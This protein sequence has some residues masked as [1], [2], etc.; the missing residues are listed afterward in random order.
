MKA[1]INIF[2]FFF[3]LF[4]HLTAQ[5]DFYRSTNVISTT[6]LS[7]RAEPSLTSK[8]LDVAPYGAKVE[9]LGYKSFGFDTI[10]VKQF[11]QKNNITRT[12]QISG[13][14]RK[15]KYKGQ[16][17]YMFSAYLSELYPEGDNFPVNRDFALLYPSIWCDNNFVF[18]PHWKWFGLYE[19]EGSEGYEW[20]KVNVSFYN[21][22]EGGDAMTSGFI[23]TGEADQGMLFMMGSMKDLRQIEVKGNWFQDWQGSFFDYRNDTIINRSEYFKKWGLQTDSLRRD[24]VT[25]LYL[26]KNG[27]SQLLNPSNWELSSPTYLK[28][29]GDLDGDG[30][31]DFLIDC[32]GDKSSHDILYLSTQADPGQLL[33]AVAAF[34]RGSCC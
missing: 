32:G 27:K 4:T 29:V 23:T 25:H 34:F 7:L 15:A 3:L 28:W 19:K 16:E 17:G 24:F 14:W 20:R 5:N 6:G 18:K 2:F 1:L 8:R 21:I 26:K 11:H 12:I 10:G 31:D 22:N 30:K 13:H 33:K 9:V